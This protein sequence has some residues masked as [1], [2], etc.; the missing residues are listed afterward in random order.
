MFLR[1]LILFITVPLVE[2]YLLLQLADV[3][4]AGATFL[5]VII[6]GIIGSALAKREGVMA[7]QKFQEALRA[8]RVPG[9]EIQ[10]GLMIVFAAALLLTPGLL[11][12][13]VGFLLLVPLGRKLMRKYVF[14]RWFR[15]FGAVQ[16]RSTTFES[17]SS[18]RAS[19]ESKFDD[20]PEF[21]L[22]EPRFNDRMTVEGKATRR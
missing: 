9:A 1:L 20:F 17:N 7:W 12:D 16:I 15:G 14:S 4:G 6:T 8:G 3:T 22:D 5:L 18:E 11:T 13:A 10:D 21:P 19:E 2:L